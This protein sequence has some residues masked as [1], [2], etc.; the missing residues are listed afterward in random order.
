MALKSQKSNEI[1]ILHTQASCLE[2]DRAIHSTLNHPQALFV[3]NDMC[4][5]RSEI[6]GF[7]RPTMT[8]TTTTTGTSNNE[9]NKDTDRSIT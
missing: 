5:T 6:N 7:D 3:D 1:T 4:L 8:T 2:M 9:D